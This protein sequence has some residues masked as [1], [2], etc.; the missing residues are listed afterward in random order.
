MKPAPKLLGCR[1][2]REI[3]GLTIRAKIV[4]TESYDQIDPA[5]HSFRDKT[6]RTEVMF[7]PSGSYR[8]SNNYVN[9][10]TYFLK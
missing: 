4:K 1:L 6:P 5:S 9:V 2:V 10:G 8:V 3:D 7:G